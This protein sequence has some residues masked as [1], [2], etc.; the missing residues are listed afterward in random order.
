MQTNVENR[1]LLTLEAIARIQNYMDC[2]VLAEANKQITDAKTKTEL[3]DGIEYALSAISYRA[4]DRPD[5]VAVYT[6][7]TEIIKDLKKE[8]EN[9]RH[10]LRCGDELRTEDD[11]ICGY[12]NLE[13]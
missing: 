3:L 5:A 9:I 7:N 2:D 10:C 6:I 8:I 1:K 12:H 13:E 4:G 11:L